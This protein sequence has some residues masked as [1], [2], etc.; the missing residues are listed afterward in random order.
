MITIVISTPEI[1]LLK[2]VFPDQ[3]DGYMFSYNIRESMKMLAQLDHSHDAYPR[4]AS[5]MAQI[6]VEMGFSSLIFGDDQL[7]VE[8]PPEPVSLAMALASSEPEDIPEEDFLATPVEE[9]EDPEDQD[10]SFALK[11]K[12]KA[13]R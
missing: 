3:L 6:A 7:A 4:F 1:D 8:H 9:Q 13:R 11:K 2:D 10:V 5:R 12:T